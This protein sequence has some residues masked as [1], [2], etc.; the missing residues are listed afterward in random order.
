[1]VVELESVQE[2]VPAVELEMVVVMVLVALA[3]IHF[4]LSH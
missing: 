2:L 3:H 1:V 4:Y